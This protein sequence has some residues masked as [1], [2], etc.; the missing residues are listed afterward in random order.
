MDDSKATNGHAAATSLVAYDSVVWIAGGLAK[1]QEF[2]DLVIASAKR[3]RA[4]VLL[5]QDR[6]RIAEA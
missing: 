4:V 1:G 2:D 5:G 3:L 6:S